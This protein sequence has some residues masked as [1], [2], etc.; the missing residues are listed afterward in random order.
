M[1]REDLIQVEGEHNLFRDR[2]TGAIVNMDSAGY[3]QYKILKQKRQNEREELDMIKN[4][5]QEIKS[6][7]REIANGS[8]SN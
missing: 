7:L 2:K 6:L 8:R 4:D 5:I 3:N 1:E